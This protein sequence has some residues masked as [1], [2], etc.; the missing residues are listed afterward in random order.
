M[1]QD[2]QASVMPDRDGR[3]VHMVAASSF[4]KKAHKAQVISRDH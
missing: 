2:R 4:L 1:K 3:K